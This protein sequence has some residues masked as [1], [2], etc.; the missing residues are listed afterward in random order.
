MIYCRIEK[1]EPEGFEPASPESK[2]PAVFQL[3]YGTI[4]EKCLRPSRQVF[5]EPKPGGPCLLCFSADTVDIMSG[6]R[7]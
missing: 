4:C 2:V 3:A 6:P 1:V 5:L 7:F